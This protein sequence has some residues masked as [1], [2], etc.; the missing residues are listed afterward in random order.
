MSGYV[1]PGINCRKWDPRQRIKVPFHHYGPT[2]RW[3]DLAGT[4]P[5][6]APGDPIRRWEDT[7]LGVD[8][9]ND[10]DGGAFWGV[11][12]SPTLA[13]PE[14]G[15]VLAV[16]SGL[17]SNNTGLYR[18]LLSVDDDPLPF[19]AENNYTFIAVLQSGDESYTSAFLVTSST[20]AQSRSLYQT[21]VDED[22]G[23]AGIASALSYNNEEILRYIQLDG[24]DGDSSWNRQAGPENFTVGPRVVAWTCSFIRSEISMWVDGQEFTVDRLPPTTQPPESADTGHDEVFSYIDVEDYPAIFGIFDYSR[25]WDIIV[26]RATLP[27]ETIR[28]CCAYYAALYNLPLVGY[29]PGTAWPP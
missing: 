5:V 21:D 29:E 4:V 7:E 19:G 6:T 26:A 20:G 16:G 27:R 22:P 1:I 14:L 9:I 28:D 12:D 24:P 8:L 17:V 18:G 25:Y 15:G 23:E 11:P 13:G 2:G 3:Q 10:G